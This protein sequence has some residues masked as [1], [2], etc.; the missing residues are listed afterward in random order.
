[1][2]WGKNVPPTERHASHP[3]TKNNGRCDTHHGTR[4]SHIARNT[5]THATRSTPSVA[6]QT[7]GY[8]GLIP[9]VGLAV[10]LWLWPA[11]RPM[12]GLA[13]LGYSATIASFLGAIH[14]GLT[15]RDAQG[16]SR[17]LLAWGVVPSLLAWVALM[18]PVASGLLLITALLWACF[19]VDSRVYPR[20]GLR[21]WLP[22]RL[23]LTAV[24]SLSCIAGAIALTQGAA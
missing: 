19:A 2:G 1:M 24:A 8:G 12:A 6:A 20:L 21:A 5:M 23:L 22:M 11:H 14:W 9:F 18:L 15:M 3:R 13:L 7:L 4:C 17:S 16:Q 10:A